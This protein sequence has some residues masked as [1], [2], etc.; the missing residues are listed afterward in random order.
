MAAVGPWGTRD[1]FN[2]PLCLF[3]EEAGIEAYT[4]DYKLASEYQFPAQ[5]EENESAQPDG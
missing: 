1:Q 4:V 2:A 3:A 5:S